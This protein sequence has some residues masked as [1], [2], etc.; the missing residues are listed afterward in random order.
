VVARDEANRAVLS[1]DGLRYAYQNFQDGRTLWVSNLDGS[2]ALKVSVHEA[3]EAA[4]SPDGKQIAYLWHEQAKNCSHIEVVAADGSTAATPK[5]LRD[6][7]ATGE[8]I[9]Q[10]AWVLR[11]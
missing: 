2:G 10:L 5:R 7:G 11:P 1:P 8:L 3:S 4:F 6:C 9:T